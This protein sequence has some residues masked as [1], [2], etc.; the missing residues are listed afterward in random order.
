MAHLADAVAQMSEAMREYIKNIAYTES[1]L[2]RMIVLANKDP[3]TNVRNKNG[4]DAYTI[5][6]QAKMRKEE[7]HFAVLM[8]DANYLKQ[9]NDT[10][11]HEKGDIYIRQC[12]EVIC[13]VFDHSPVFRIGGDEFAVILL[14]QDYSNRHLLLSNVRD[15]FQTLMNDKTLEPWERGSVAIG[16]A[17]YQ[18]E[19]DQSVEDV[20]RR[21]DQ[22][23]YNEKQ[24]MKAEL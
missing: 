2:A 19:T 9:I 24:K 12:C 15:T 16:I 18:P 17:E 13:V 10:Y 3:L 22:D 1:E 14:G 20:L 8:V 23:M 21:A 11:G 4:F 5:E 7:I 6:L